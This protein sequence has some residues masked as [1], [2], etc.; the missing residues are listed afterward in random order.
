MTLSTIFKFAF[1]VMASCS[2]DHADSKHVRMVGG[3]VA[4]PGDFK[5]QV[6]VQ[7]NHVHM[8]GGALISDQHVLTAAHCL[9]NRPDNHFY[10]EKVQGP[11][12]VKAAIKN[13]NDPNFVYAEVQE[14]AVSDLYMNSQELFYVYDFAILKLRTK[15]DLRNPNVQVVKLPAFNT[16]DIYTGKYADVAGWGTAY[17]VVTKTYVNPNELLAL[18]LEIW[19]TEYCNQV[20]GGNLQVDAENQ[21]CGYAPRDDGK[22]YGTCQGDSGSPL[23][24]Q[25]TVIGVASSA[26]IPCGRE[27]N[28]SV[29]AR[30]S[31]YIPFIRDAMAGRYSSEFAVKRF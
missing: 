21:I 19:D 15:I 18:T 26:P 28:P 3:Y 27:H 31:S 11:L 30:I 8:C 4:K 14:L 2:V 7:S 1:L 29:F 23:V 9:V 20:F 24:Y 13:L 5:Y 22:L 10:D 16:Q 6:S 17:N 25:G 12:T